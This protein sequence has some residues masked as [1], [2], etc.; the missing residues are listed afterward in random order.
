V[1]SFGILIFEILTFHRPF[2]DLRGLAIQEKLLDSKKTYENLL[3]H[4][5]KDQIQEY[6]PLLRL[7][8]QCCSLEPT[9]RPTVSFVIIALKNILNAPL[10]PRAANEGK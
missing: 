4:L 9:D 5:S 10:S 1:Y 7:F 3:S 6:D 8:S 2:D